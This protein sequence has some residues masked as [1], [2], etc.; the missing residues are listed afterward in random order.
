VKATACA[1]CSKATERWVNA[2]TNTH[3]Q[4][5]K[6]HVCTYLIFLYICMCAQIHAHICMMRIYARY[7]CINAQI[8][9]YI[10]TQGVHVYIIRMYMCNTR[11][12]K[13]KHTDT[14]THIHR[15]SPRLDSVALALHIRTAELKYMHTCTF[16]KIY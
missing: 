3:E 2:H 12:H 6:F 7:V 16:N 13:C 9:T 15:L 11:T 4:R 14:K 10:H 8:Q 1:K 5:K